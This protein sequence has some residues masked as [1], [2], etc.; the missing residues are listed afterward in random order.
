MSSGNIAGS[1]P[2]GTVTT[3]AQFPLPS[4]S[5]GNAATQL[6]NAQ[7]SVNGIVNTDAS[8]NQSGMTDAQLALMNE[9]GALITQV[10]ALAQQALSMGL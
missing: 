5:I 1:L 8:G 4:A 10:Q 3:P 7:T 6:G 2:G 9:I